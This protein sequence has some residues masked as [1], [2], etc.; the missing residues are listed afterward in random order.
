MILAGTLLLTQSLPALAADRGFGSRIRTIERSP[1]GVTFRLKL[2]NAPFPVSAAS[3]QDAS[4]FVFVPSYFRADR[5]GLS[6]LVHFHG[7]NTTA[8]RA[9]TAHQLREQLADS[10]QNAILVV[11]QGPVLAADSS[12][13]KLEAPGG[14]RALLQEVALVLASSE[15]TA[16]LGSSKVLRG[17]GL[18]RVC[19]SG[20]SGG[21]HA[22]AA[23][24]KQGGVTV[25]EAYLFDALYAD[26]EVFKSWMLGGRIAGQPKR[27]LVSMATGG[28]PLANTEALMAELAR[29]GLVCVTEKKEGAIS[30]ED[31]VRADAVFLQSP[32]T[33]QDVTFEHNALRDCLYASAL[34]RHVKTSW[35]R[36]ARGPR[37]IEK[38]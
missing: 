11:P 14:L 37:P 8:E 4:V 28:A 9:L 34:P 12:A 5:S 21:Y 20:H 19:L 18:G 32:L 24:L 13:G 22:V 36:A 26:A 16:E 29:A 33:H 17:T 2:R 1:I 23:C 35:F 25:S 10:K 30:R 31:L 15:A 38:R 3:Y 7:H 6:A 27:K